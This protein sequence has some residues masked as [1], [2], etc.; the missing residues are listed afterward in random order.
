VLGNQYGS[1]DLRLNYTWEGWGAHAYHQRYF[2]DKSGMEFVNGYDGLWG[3]Q[4]DLPPAL[5][6]LQKVVFE[7]LETRNQSGP[8]HFIEFD[9]EAHPGVG[10]GSDNYY[11]NGEYTTGLSYFNRGLGSPLLPSPEYNLDGSL[12]FRNT[13]VHSLHFGLSGSLSKQVGY[14]LLFTSMETWG[15]HSRP[16]LDKKTG[17]SGLCEVAYQPAC[18]KG[19]T[20]TGMLAADR[21]DFLNKKGIG[22]GI[23]ISKRGIVPISRTR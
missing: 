9:H 20:F 10:G 22:G 18:L 7:I 12:G 4:L 14:R 3:L 15:S 23:I 21:G 16:Y 13:R 8:F 19:W 1:Y 5:P 6:W 11:N 17:M 2:E